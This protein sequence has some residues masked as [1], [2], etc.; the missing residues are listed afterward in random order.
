MFDF[1]LDYLNQLNLS[2]IES[3]VLIED[4]EESDWYSNIDFEDI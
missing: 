2:W 4:P 3:C 1:D